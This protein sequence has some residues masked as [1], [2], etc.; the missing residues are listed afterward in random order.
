MNLKNLGLEELSLSEKKEVN[1]GFWQFFWG[2]ILGGIISDVVLH[3]G[4]TLYSFNNG[5]A[6][7]NR[8]RR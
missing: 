1:G 3:P 7:A 2:A 6:E 4:E 5:R 8:M